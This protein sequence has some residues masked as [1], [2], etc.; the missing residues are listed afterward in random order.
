MDRLWVLTALL[1]TLTAFVPA[2][3]PGGRPAQT[4]Q[5]AW[6]SARG[7]ETG[8]SPAPVL[9]RSEVCPTDLPGTR[10][11]AEDTANGVALVFT[12]DNGDVDTLRRSVV[13]L[14]NAHS[15]AHHD[16]AAGGARGGGPAA[17]GTMPSAHVAAE[18]VP[19]GARLVL[20]PT[21]PSGLERLRAWARDVVRGA[22]SGPG[23]CPFLSP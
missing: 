9:A 18:Y 17:A 20:T 2:C 22:V 11:R 5:V 14:A 3:S 6:Y 7:A 23:L 21:D 15:A 13:R 8:A 4:Q 10:V 19:G 1:G 16:G 12:S